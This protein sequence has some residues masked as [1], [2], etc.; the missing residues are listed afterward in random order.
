LAVTL[1][2][3]LGAGYLAVVERGPQWIRMAAI[4]LGLCLE[5]FWW[6]CG[7]L[8][9]LLGGSNAWLLAGAAIVNVVVWSLVAGAAAAIVRRARLR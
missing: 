8:G 9:G 2:G 7:V 5:P 4:V 3:V 1:L 6:T